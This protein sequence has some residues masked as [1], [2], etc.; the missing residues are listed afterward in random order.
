MCN[1]DCTHQ[2]S[3]PPAQSV[4]GCVQAAQSIISTDRTFLPVHSTRRSMYQPNGSR[5]VYRVISW[6]T[7]NTMRATPHGDS[8]LCVT[9]CPTMTVGSTFERISRCLLTGPALSD[10]GMKKG[11]HGNS[12]TKSV[13]WW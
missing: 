8:I 2:W 11:I 12:H 3:H 1:G 7:A 6:W 4:E 13:G 10:R 9:L 5:F